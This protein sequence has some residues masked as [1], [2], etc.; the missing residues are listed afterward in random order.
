MLALLKAERPSP[1]AFSQ[2]SR[3][4]GKTGKISQNL[5]S[6]VFPYDSQSGKAREN[7]TAPK[8]NQHD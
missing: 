8:S 1:A 5:Y 3:K 2:L 7:F 4:T 6:S